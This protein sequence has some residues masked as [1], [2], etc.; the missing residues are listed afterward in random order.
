MGKTSRA[1]APPDPNVV[2]AAQTAAERDAAGYNNAITHGN[3]TTP[4][5][6]QTYT[7]RVD[8]TTGA[9]VYD[10]SITLDPTQQQLL[11]IYNQND[12]TFGQASQGMLGRVTDQFAGPMDTS[13][14][15]DLQGSVQQGQF[16]NAPNLQSYNNAPTLQSYGSAPQMGG[17]QGQLNTSG[18]P[19]LAGSGG[20][21]DQLSVNGPGIQGRLDTGGLPEL[22]GAND[23]QG[24]RQQV[25]DSL[26][27]RQSAYL[28]PQWQQ[29]D[30]AFRSR[31]ANQGIAEGSEAWNNAFQ[32]ED[33]ARSFDYGRARESAIAGGGDELSRL[34][35]VAQGNRGQMFGERQAAGGFQNSAQAQALA[36]ALASGNFGNNAR[37][38]NAAFQNSARGQ[39]FN[40]AQA[41]GNFANSATGAGN[42]DAMSQAA[43]NRA[44]TVQGN[45]DAMSQAAFN[46]AGIAQGN[47]DAMSQAGFN[48]AA[49]AA[50]NAS[51][52]QQAQ[53]GNQARAQGLEQLF[54]L[55][56]QPLNE[57]N[58]LRSSAQVAQPQFQN[59]QNSLT[60]AADAQ[61]NINQN[62]QQQMNIWNAQQQAR[63]NFMSGLFGLG[64]SFLGRP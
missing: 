30:T 17:Y 57:Y 54:A 51:A 15:P 32:N 44:G 47:S 10:Q 28:D 8:P 61:G 6:S 31:M 1:P 5:G 64:S 41:Q 18:L 60:N 37:M 42:Q 27:S 39:G 11:D 29:R 58:A 2:S 21:S 43:F 25:Q 13:S 62:Y 45:Q 20:Q 35:N 22:Y 23:L 9:T 7:G 19:G 16:G 36:E 50:N 24:A 52:M 34:V 48:Q 46:Q 4:W 3:T 26:Y 38:A 53:F 49:T 55:R 59:A 12:L 40:E 33:R 14:L 56:N 63:N